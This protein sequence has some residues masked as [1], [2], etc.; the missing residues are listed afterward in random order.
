MMRFLSVLTIMLGCAGALAREI[1]RHPAEAGSAWGKLAGTTVTIQTVDGVNL[2]GIHQPST[3]GS[4][5][6]VVMIPML[7]SAMESY[8]ELAAELQKRGHGTLVYDQ[9]GHGLSRQSKSGA[10]DYRRFT[11]GPSGDWARTAD[12]LGA[13]VDWLVTKGTAPDQI[14]IVGASI[15]SSA[16]LLYAQRNPTVSPLVLLSPGENYRGLNVMAAASQIKGRNVLIVTGTE[17]KYSR[18][19][20]QKLVQAM[21]NGGSNVDL[22]EIGTSNHGTTMLIEQTVRQIASWLETH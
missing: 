7:G 4:T 16:A 15:G 9:R 20:S 8:H 19:S 6:T 13:V 2:V 5:L 14:A 21:R 12:D 11:D 22:Q 1:P 17:D 3:Q 18:E 10:V